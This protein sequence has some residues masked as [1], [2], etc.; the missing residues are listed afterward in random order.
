MSES[1]DKE[2]MKGLLKR[3]PEQVVDGYEL[4]G[5][6]A[7]EDIDK[8]MIAGM[9]GSA[10]SGE[11]LL[12]YLDEKI[13]IFINK[14][15][16]LPN[17]VD[18]HTLVF[19]ISYSGNTEETIEAYRD[20][21]RRGCKLVVITSGGKLDI[22]ARKNS[23]PLVLV[24]RGIQ[25][26]LTYGYIFFAILR[27]LANSKIIKTMEK[28]VTGL[29]ATLK[30]DVFMK[31]GEELA[32]HL[33]GRIPIIYASQAM[34]GVAYKWKINFN[35]NSKIH[36]FCNVIPEMNHNEILGYT[37]LNG[38]YYGIILKNDTDHV[39]V[40]LRM[41]LTKK[42][43]KEKGVEV[44]EIGITGANHLSKLFSAIYIGDWVSYFLSIK[45]NVDPT[46]VKIIETLKK[47][48]AR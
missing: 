27:V 32:E 23:H 17:F 41:D 14:D 25:P 18:S 39:R 33:V 16:T 47:D 19:A 35:E 48:L 42:I 15:Y 3:F 11:I 2:D 24:P 43:M 34:A 26:R 6:T 30:Q 8:I 22:L 29:Y 44:T 10:L 31:R 7:V 36:A 20:A 21:I 28:E 45:N 13:P 37:D 5:K 4:G 1:I 38:D 40:K 9:G 12:S 46:P